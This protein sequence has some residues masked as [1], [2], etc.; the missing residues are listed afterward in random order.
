MGPT[1]IRIPFLFVVALFFGHLVQRARSA[2]REAYEAR[3]HERIGSEFIHGVVHDLK[4]PLA[5]IKSWAEIVLEEAG[6][7]LSENHA[8]LI[9]RIH[10]NAQRMLR[11]SLNLLD[12]APIEAG[13]LSL[14]QEQVKLTDLAEDDVIGSDRERSLKISLNFRVA[15]A[16]HT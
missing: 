8:D 10:A 3:E 1:P 16:T 2:E 7:T 6:K 13:R 12:K 15:D 5:V 14:Q 11:L 4:T 9:R